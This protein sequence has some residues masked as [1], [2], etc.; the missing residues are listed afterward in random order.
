MLPGSTSGTTKGRGRLL[1]F[2]VRRFLGAIAGR[3]AILLVAAVLLFFGFDARADPSCPSGQI[4]KF[5][6]PSS[7]DAVYASTPGRCTAGQVFAS[8]TALKSACIPLHEVVSTGAGS[9]THWSGT[10]TTTYDG[11]VSGITPSTRIHNSSHSITGAIRYLF[12]AQWS[13]APANCPANGTPFVGNKN[14]K[15][16]FGTRAYVTSGTSICE[17]VG[18]GGVCV[19]IPGGTDQGVYCP[20]WLYTGNPGTVASEAGTQPLETTEKVCTADGKICTGKDTASNCGTVNGEY[21]CVGSPAP[22]GCVT[23]PK[24]YTV[25][26]GTPAVPITTPPAPANPTEPGVVATPAVSIVKPDGSGGIVTNT[27]TNVYNPGGAST[28]GSTGTPTGT[29][30]TEPTAAGS[31]CGGPGQ[32]ACASNLDCGGVGEPLCSVKVDETGVDSADDNFEAQLESARTAADVAES[33][34]FASTISTLGS[35]AASNPGT[36]WLPGDLIPDV[37][38]ASCQTISVSF[39]GGIEKSFPTPILCDFIEDKLKPMLAFF[40]WVVTAGMIVF[41]AIRT[42]SPGGA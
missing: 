28:P 22:G 7:F 25:C 39:F 34:T 33:D 31:T 23:T 30:T 27:T 42:M 18:G 5:T 37:P 35:G 8:S 36:G 40:L 14:M 1:P 41:G 2:F 19:Q 15:N 38:E 26:T 4:G 21:Q 29:P 20:S 9:T 11:T 12:T 16:A 13:C 10:D 32:P 6:V 24:G 3:L 17:V